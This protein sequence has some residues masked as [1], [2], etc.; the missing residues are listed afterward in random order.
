MVEGDEITGLVMS[1][2][3]MGLGVEHVFLK[4]VVA[5]CGGVA[6]KA[7]IIETPRNTPVRNIYRENGFAR[8][9]EGSWR[10]VA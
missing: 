10:L 2:R 3:V 5:A 4:H 6:L 8:D 7:R 1:C 9:A